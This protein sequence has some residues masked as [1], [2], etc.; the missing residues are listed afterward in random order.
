MSFAFYTKGAENFTDVQQSKVDA[1]KH[2]ID[3]K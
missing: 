1:K 3:E 2:L